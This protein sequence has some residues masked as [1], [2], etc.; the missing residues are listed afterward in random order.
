MPMD[1]NTLRFAWI[2]LES[3]GLETEGGGVLEI[4]CI[5]TDRF[6]NEL[7]R[8][9]S[10][11]NPG[12][13]VLKNMND[14]VT[15]MHTENGLLETVRALDTPTTEEADENFAE[16]LKRFN[17]GEPKNVILAGN[18]VAGVDIPFKKVFLPLSDA[19]MHYR[20]LD[21]TSVRI[22]AGIW[23]GHDTDFEK[24][25]GHRAFDDILECLEEFRYVGAQL[26]K[27]RE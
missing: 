10:L 20:Y 3:T 19:E 11:V 12:E 27:P 22:A 16:F 8:F 13:D 17:S 6:L 21:V 1:Y 9:H 18:S 26:F 5:I 4:A 2:D 7:G 24:S 15:N 14:Y 23:F 25:R